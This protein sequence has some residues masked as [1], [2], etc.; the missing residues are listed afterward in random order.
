MKTKHIIGIATLTAGLLM[1]T[2]VFAKGNGSGSAKGNQAN[3]Q[4]G[5][6][7]SADAK[8]YN[9]GICDGSGPGQGTPLR[10]GSGKAAKGKN[11]GNAAGNGE[12][13]RDG[14]GRTNGGK[15]YGRNNDGTC[16]N[17]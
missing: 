4:N 1:A 10:D 2:P 14:S 12:P 6:T 3:G 9:Q 17:R 7:Q 15:G 11:K 13:L 16:P 8:A 5:Y